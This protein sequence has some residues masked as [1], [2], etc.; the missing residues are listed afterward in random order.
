MYLFQN[1][2]STSMVTCTLDSDASPCRG[3]SLWN[4]LVTNWII[5]QMLPM[6]DKFTATVSNYCYYFKFTPTFMK[7]KE[8]K[9]RILTNLCDSV[10]QVNIMVHFTLARLSSENRE[11][12]LSRAWALPSLWT[13][14]RLNFRCRL[15]ISYPSCRMF[16][17]VA[18]L[19][20]GLDSKQSSEP[21]QCQIPPYSNL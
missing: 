1:V 8:D 19:R 14:F 10:I 15:W 17:Q 4:T 6:R 16:T 21:S 9:L 12:S 20:L 11:L 5:V 3:V 2:T 7:T 13:G 18:F